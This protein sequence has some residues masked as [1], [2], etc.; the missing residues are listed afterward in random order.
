MSLLHI[1][2][3]QR[4]RRWRSHLRAVWDSGRYDGFDRDSI[5]VF[6]SIRNK[7]GPSGLDSIKFP[8]PPG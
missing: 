1:Y 8:D 6:Q 4:G 3:A 5:A 2:A 7:I